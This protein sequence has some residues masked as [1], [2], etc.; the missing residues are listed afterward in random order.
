MLFTGITCMAGP[1]MEN[2]L[3]GF[4]TSHLGPCVEMLS[5]LSYISQTTLFTMSLQLNMETMRNPLAAIPLAVG[6]RNGAI[7][8]RRIAPN[9]PA[10][11]LEQAAQNCG[12]RRSG[13]V[14]P[15]YP[16]TSESSVS[17]LG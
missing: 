13:D 12:V 16:P 10:Y 5:L 7:R 1:P 3:S 6:L 14:Y 15:W 17:T 4:C 2:G 8:A 9:C 11:T